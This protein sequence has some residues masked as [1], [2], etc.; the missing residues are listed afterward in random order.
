MA[1]L[2]KKKNTPAIVEEQYSDVDDEMIDDNV[3]DIEDQIDPLESTLEAVSQVTSEGLGIIHEVWLNVNIN[4]TAAELQKTP[5]KRV[6]KVK[7]H[8]EDALKHNVAVTGRDAAGEDNL[9][10][11]P[12]NVVIST[13]E[14]Y[15]DRNTRAFDIRWHCSDQV[16]TSIDSDKAGFHFTCA[17]SPMLA[18][19]EPMNKLNSINIIDQKSLDEA[20]GMTLADI[21]NMVKIIPPDP[22]LKTKGYGEITIGSL[23]HEKL[24]SHLKL[25]RF[26]NYYDNETYERMMSGR[27]TFKIDV[28]LKVAETIKDVLE[29]PILKLE[30]RSTDL[31]ATE[32]TLERADGL[33]FDSPLQLLGQVAG[34]P[35]DKAN[36]VS[37][38]SPLR[39]E[40]SHMLL[41]VQ[42]RSTNL[43]VRKQ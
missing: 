15:R 40:N 2:G 6:W 41:R 12:H 9:I 11:D 5:A 1:H 8:L 7:D 10:G 30:G 24:E 29:A 31:L 14:L 32:F 33:P 22:K 25:S 21:A 4:E 3:E 27:R 16:G 17:N 43:A 26:N 28:P 20:Q 18:M 13:L 35:L 37:T 36:A 23:A 42:F 34:D 19:P 39:Y 38:N